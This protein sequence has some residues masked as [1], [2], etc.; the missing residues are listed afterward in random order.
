[1]GD[2]KHTSSKLRRLWP[3]RLQ[4]PLDS[5]CKHTVPEQDA[6]A[7]WPQ[8]HI[9]EMASTPSRRRVIHSRG[10]SSTPS[11]APPASLSGI[12]RPAGYHSSD[13]NRRERQA[14]PGCCWTSHHTVAPPRPWDSGVSFQ[15]APLPG[16]SKLGQPVEGSRE[17][18]GEVP[19]GM[20]S[21]GNALVFC[22][23][24]FLNNLLGRFL[25]G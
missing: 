22:L 21:R 19:G 6:G 18:E 3:S 25:E 8:F 14:L 7:L 12:H 13:R 5:E 4:P 9:S 16:P 17:A 15:A 1:M 20:G 10:T 11:R 2:T 24:S 23:T